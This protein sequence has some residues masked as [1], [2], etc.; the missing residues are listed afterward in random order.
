MGSTGGPTTQTTSWTRIFKTIL[1]KK[2]P[3]WQATSSHQDEIQVI[4]VIVEVINDENVDDFSLSDD[5]NDVSKLFFI[6][7]LNPYFVYS[8][9]TPGSSITQAQWMLQKKKSE[10]GKKIVVEKR[11][12]K[13]RAQKE[14]LYVLR[15]VIA[16]LYTD[17]LEE[18][19]KIL[20]NDAP[21]RSPA[22]LGTFSK[23]VAKVLRTLTKNQMREVE[24]A[25][26]IW[27]EIG[28]PDKVKA[29]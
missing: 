27:N 5:L 12:S 16:E 22:W 17:H 2:A 7:P 21:N 14:K 19:I 26:E 9:C 24:D 10:S 15:D 6:L 13:T 28:A 8:V 18:K 20:C 4:E 3:A 25:L 11:R 23:A 1:G 29:K